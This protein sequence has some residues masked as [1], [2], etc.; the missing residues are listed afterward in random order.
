MLSGTLPVPEY[1]IAMG[2]VWRIQDK[3]TTPRSF[4]IGQCDNSIHM[5]F[6]VVYKN[7]R[8]RTEKLKVIFTFKHLNKI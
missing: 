5:A 7:K 1:S 4:I 3:R 6:K 8:I 2:R